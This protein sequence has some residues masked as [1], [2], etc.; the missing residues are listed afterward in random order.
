LFLVAYSVERKEIEF[1][2]RLIDNWW[3]KVKEFAESSDKERFATFKLPPKN[4]K[5]LAAYPHL[6]NQETT[7]RLIKVTLI[8]GE[9]VV[10]YTFLTDAEEY[11]NEEFEELYH[12][13]WNEEEAYKL[14]KCRDELE[15]F[16]EK[17]TKAIKQD[18]FAKVFL[19]KLCAAY[20][21]PIEEKV[22]QEYNA[23][24]NRKHNKKINRTIAISMAQDIMIAVMLRKHFFKA[25]TAFDK[26]LAAMREII[27]PGRNIPRKMKQK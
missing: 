5:K 7:C 27:R 19:S 25:I 11:P 9:T 13:R 26:V 12:L 15:N 3:L 21:H 24:Q 8:T 4:R 22:K 14:L 2:D 6:I 1:C 10:L 23:D 16:S 18:L 20:A 17:T